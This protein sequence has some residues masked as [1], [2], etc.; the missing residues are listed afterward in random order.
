[1]IHEVLLSSN[2]IKVLDSALEFYI[3]MGLGQISEIG[4]RL[5]TLLYKRI[6]LDLEE[7]QQILDTLEN[8]LLGGVTPWKLGDE[9]TS[10]YTVAAYGI[11]ALLHENK[12]GVSWAAKRLR[13]L[14]GRDDL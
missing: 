6:N 8:K 3:A 4:L 14:K 13:E 11:Q 7:V 9:D 5:R 12:D 2:Q 1:M 10:A